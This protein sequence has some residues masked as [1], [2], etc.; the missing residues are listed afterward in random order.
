MS[1]TN[2]ADTTRPGTDE[3]KATHLSELTK[4]DIFIIGHRQAGGI[5]QA[6]SKR[7]MYRSTLLIIIS[8]IYTDHLKKTR[9]EDDDHCSSLIGGG[10]RLRLTDV[11]NREPSEAP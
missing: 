7:G 1:D 4:P 10:P 5:L 2:E 11:I 6:L 3:A 8:I 9:L